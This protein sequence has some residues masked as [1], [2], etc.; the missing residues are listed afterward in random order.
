[1][2]LE[3]ALDRNSAAMEKH[4]ALLTKVMASG[5]L[6]SAAAGDGEAATAPRRGRPPG[7]G[8]PKGPTFDEVKAIAER[9]RDERSRPEAIALMKKHGAAKIVEL[10][11]SKYAAFVAAAEVLLAADDNDAGGDDDI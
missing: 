8:K 3:E 7:S 10:D 2:S 4:S 5:G 6:P 1:M 11:E 9:V